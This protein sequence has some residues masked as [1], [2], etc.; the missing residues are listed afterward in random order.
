MTCK[1]RGDLAREGLFAAYE[2]SRKKQEF[3]ST[4]LRLNE[5]FGLFS[6]KELDLRLQTC[7]LA[8]MRGL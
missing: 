4:V 5:G 2:Y 3:L 6:C 7:S 8:L 1:E